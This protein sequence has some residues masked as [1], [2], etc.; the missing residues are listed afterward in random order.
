MI[1]KKYVTVSYPDFYRLSETHY[2][3]LPNTNTQSTLIIQTT[4]K[5]PFQANKPT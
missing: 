2:Y 4:L 3:L 1:N 5:K